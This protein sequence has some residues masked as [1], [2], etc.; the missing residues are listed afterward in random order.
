MLPIKS[1]LEFCVLQLPV[2]ESYVCLTIVP[3]RFDQTEIHEYVMQHTQHSTVIL[4]CQPVTHTHKIATYIRLRD[5][6]TVS[7]R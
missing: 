4:S 5:I 1:E 6:R 2:R 3:K 7:L